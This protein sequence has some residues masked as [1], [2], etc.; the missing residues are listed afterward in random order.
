M[1]KDGPLMAVTD[2]AG[3]AIVYDLRAIKVLKKMKRFGKLV[4][5]ILGAM[6]EP[7]FMIFQKS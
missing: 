6:I 2:D 1:Q 5:Y 7:L 4:R 3:D